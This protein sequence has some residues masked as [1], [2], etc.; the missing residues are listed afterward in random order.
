MD[1]G[2]KQM[3]EKWVKGQR[4]ETRDLARIL[5]AATPNPTTIGDD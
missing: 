5:L 3:E 4:R 2:E 1:E